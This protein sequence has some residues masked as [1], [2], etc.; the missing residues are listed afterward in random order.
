MVW[1][2]VSIDRS[3]VSP[4]E[5][6]PARYH[7]ASV[8]HT[9][10][11]PRLPQAIRVRAPTFEKGVSVQTPPEAAEHPSENVGS[12]PNVLHLAVATRSTGER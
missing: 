10:R 9:T 2:P 7:Q 3:T 11:S 12:M 8:G 4:G 6:E 5:I 1:G